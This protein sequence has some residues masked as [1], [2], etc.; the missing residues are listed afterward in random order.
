M[1]ASGR[2]CGVAYEAQ[3][4]RLEAAECGDETV[5][6]TVRRFGGLGDSLVDEP[7]L[8]FKRNQLNTEADQAD[9]TAEWLSSQLLRDP[10]SALLERVAGELT[11]PDRAVETAAA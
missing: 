9:A 5:V 6:T 1:R 8:E 4:L 7:R 11:L 10:D 3:R 2:C